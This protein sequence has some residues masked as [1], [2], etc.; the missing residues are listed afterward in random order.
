MILSSG[1][2]ENVPW[3]R[4]S[5]MAPSMSPSPSPTVPSTTPLSEAMKVPTLDA[6]EPFANRLSECA[7]DVCGIRQMYHALYVSPRE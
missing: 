4:A 1:Q 5:P 7:G 2:S 6:P 3:L